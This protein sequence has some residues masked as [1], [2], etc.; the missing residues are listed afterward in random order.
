[1]LKASATF[2]RVLFD[3]GEFGTATEAGS[4]EEEDFLGL[5]ACS[6]PTR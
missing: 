3:G 5:P 4:P 1:M 2:D 6:N